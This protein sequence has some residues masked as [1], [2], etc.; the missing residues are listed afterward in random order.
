MIFSENIQWRVIPRK[1]NINRCELCDLNLENTAKCEAS[2][3]SRARKYFALRGN[4]PEYLSIEIVISSASVITR[5]FRSLSFN[6]HDLRSM[7]AKLRAFT[8][9]YLHRLYLKWNFSAMW[10]GKMSRNNGF[11]RPSHSAT[12]FIQKCRQVTFETRRLRLITY[13]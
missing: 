5:H 12:N 9:F 3:H 2:H 6:T 1:P 8:F 13:R 7:S 10:M 11:N 4:S